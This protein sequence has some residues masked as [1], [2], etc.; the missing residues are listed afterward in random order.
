MAE[1]VVVAT[2]AASPEP[3]DHKRKL[4][5]LD[6]EPTE[7]TEEN[8]AE[9]IEG[10][11]APDAADVPISDES[12]YKRPRLEGKPE[13][14]ASENG[15]EEKKEEE[16]EPKEDYKQSSEEEPPASVEVLPE[17]EGTEQPTEEPHE[18]GDAQDSAAEISQDSAAEISQED[19]TQELSKE[20]SQPSEVEAAPPLQ[21]EDISNAE[22]D[23]P[24]SESETT[25]YKMEVPNSKVGVLIG[26][27]GDTIRYLQYNSGAKIQIMRDAEADPNRLTRPVEIIGTSENIKKAEELINAVIAE[28]DAGG[29]PS[30]IARGLTSSHSIATA[31]QIQLQVP[32]EKVGLI[33]GR[34]GETIKSLQTRSGARIQLIPQNLPEGDESKERTIRVTGDK[35]QIEIATD[36]IKEVMNQTVRPSPHSTGFNQQAYRPR[37]PGG[38][39]QWGHRGPHPS[40]PAGYDYP[41]RGPYP[42]HNTQYQHPG[43]GNYPQQ[44]GGPRSSYGSGWEQRPPP[45]MQGPPP[46]S[47]GYDYYGQRSH[48]SDAPP[49]HFPG[50]MP[51]HAPGPSP[52]PTHGPPQTQSSYNYNQQQGQGYGH[53]APYSQAAPH[54]SY[55]HG[56]EQK[57]DHHAPAQNPYSGHGNAQH[58]PQA[59]TQQVY[60]GQQY[61]NKPS[62][63]GVS[64]QGPPPQ[65]YGAPR[66]GQPAEPYQGGSAP[67]TYGQNMQPQQTYPYQSGGSTQ[68]YPP[69]GAAPSTDGYNQAPAASAAAGYSQ[70]GAQAG[71]G[72]PS[73]QQPSAYGQQVAPAAA[74]GQYPTSQQGY[75]E[76][77]AAN[78]AAG[79]AAYQAPQDPAA[80]SGGTAAA[81]AAYTAP[82]SGQQGY[83][84]QTATQP[85]YD[86]SIQQSG[87]YGTVPSSAPVGYGKS[88]SPQPQPGYP[89]YDSTQV[90]GA[91]R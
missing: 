62:S 33:I 46:S 21:E 41:H 24:S 39:T 26:K 78:T 14:N 49:S 7:A 36:M 34:G 65:S 9:P 25:T 1:E 85:T 23:Q 77:A 2:G 56:Y 3:L 28:A 47:G 10:S 37:G 87:G 59:G 88:V 52:A 6:S 73:V 50:A 19:K 90:Y 76:Q 84:Q 38:P 89:Q 55:G 4:V 13:G 40:H 83:T 42:S 57:Y 70:Q 15:H 32:N 17:K 71:Y 44:M 91:S 63:Y 11:A 64:Q 48:Y 54:Q 68:Q 5:D 61:D 22:Q 79:Y 67:A 43:Y 29:S 82:A 16:L 51:S 35:K 60:P 12:E 20:E 31:E 72:Q 75:S 53:T 86:Q 18:A 45:S 27:A 69:Y 66:V 80:Y 81:A 74:Y 58:Y 8:H 30:L